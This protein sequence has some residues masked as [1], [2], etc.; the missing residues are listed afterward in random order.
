MSFFH[1]GLLL[2][3]LP[4][5]QLSVSL[6]LSR[7]LPAAFA[8]P[9]AQSEDSSHA[10]IIASEEEL[11]IAHTCS[12]VCSFPLVFWHILMIDFFIFSGI[13]VWHRGETKLDSFDCH[14]YCK[15]ITGSVESK[16]FTPQSAQTAILG[17]F[18][19]L[20]V[21]PSQRDCHSQNCS[22]TVSL[23]LGLR[24]P[25]PTDS[26]KFRFPPLFLC[27]LSSPSCLSM[28]LLWTTMHHA[29]RRFHLFS[30][31]I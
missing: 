14:D 20:P 25:S 11:F 24:V 2:F 30:M 29:C 1:C 8:F 6:L 13:C 5:L 10:L 7:C 16:A 26:V 12:C 15:Y 3:C 22:K 18:A 9:F 21:D 19:Q 4:F 17:H 31:E 28:F 27:T 23:P